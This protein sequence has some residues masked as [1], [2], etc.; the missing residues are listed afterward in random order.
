MKYEVTI[1]N[2]TKEQWEF[3]AGDFADYSIYQTW[4]YQQVRGEAD[5]QEVSRAVVKDANGRAATMCHVRV[6]HVKALGLRI[7]YVQWGPLMRAKDGTLKCS[8]E[9]LNILRDAYLGSRVNI[10]RVVPNVCNSEAGPEVIRLLRAS[11]FN[12][13]R[14]VKPYYTMFLSLN[15]PEET[16]RGRLHQSWRRKLRKAEAAG[17]ELREKT[18]DE[19]F[20]ILERFY[21]DTVQR[22]GFKGLDPREFAAAQRILASGEKMKLMVAYHRGEPVT[23]HVTSNL[24]DAAIL[25]LVA[26]NETGLELGASYL[27]WWQAILA[28]ARRMMKRYDVGGIDFENNPTVSRFKAGMGGE[29][30][31]HIGAFEACSGA[32]V[33]NLWRTAE[34][35]YQLI[36][37]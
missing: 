22:K 28:S 30:S 23:V 24:G 6:K 5:G 37:K 21:L 11:G 4:G 8:I 1:D 35:A 20:R 19:S 26:S 32:M 31:C 17:L 15:C 9:A 3:H 27:A 16:L 7:G 2:L 10:L 13:V 14:G 29:E 12:C 33:R 25:L 18:D 36:G 34:K